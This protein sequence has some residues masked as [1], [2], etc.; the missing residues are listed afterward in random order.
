LPKGEGKKIISDFLMRLLQNPQRERASER[1]CGEN[2]GQTGGEWREAL[3]GGRNPGIWGEFRTGG[4]LGDCLR[5]NGAR[6]E[7][8]SRANRAAP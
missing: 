5:R 8:L 7:A 6:R 4:N 2:W 1:G 3:T